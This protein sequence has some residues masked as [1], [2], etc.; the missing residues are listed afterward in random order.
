MQAGDANTDTFTLTTGGTAD[1]NRRVVVTNTLFTFY[2]NLRIEAPL[3]R[4]STDDTLVISVGDG[5]HPAVTETLHLRTGGSQAAQERLSVSADGITLHENLLLNGNSITG[6]T[7]SNLSDVENLRI[8]RSQITDLS[9]LTLAFTSITGS[10][11]Y[12]RLSGAPDLSGYLTTPSQGAWTNNYLRIGN[13]DSILQVGDVDTGTDDNESLTIR[14]GGNTAGHTRMV[15]TNTGTTL[16]GN[17]VFDTSRIVQIGTTSSDTLIF[18][19]RWYW[20]R[21]RNE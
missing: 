11:P 3:P 14:T 20:V 8:T 5:T 7:V 15:V 21:R 16:H 10:L 18:C 9:A 12:T 4:I 2:E 19:C 6:L 1:A 17:L 13:A